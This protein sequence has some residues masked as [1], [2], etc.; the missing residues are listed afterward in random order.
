M[1]ITATEKKEC[2]LSF[3]TTLELAWSKISLATHLYR[4]S[5]AY[6]GHFNHSVLE[7]N[8]NNHSLFRAN[9]SIS[10]NQLPPFFRHHLLYYRRC[11][12]KKA[13]LLIEP[14]LLRNNL[15]L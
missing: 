2:F 10:L 4:P 13:I 14:S 7:T 8:Y 3:K 12:L 5:T 9:I 6:E 1:L 15:Y 11:H